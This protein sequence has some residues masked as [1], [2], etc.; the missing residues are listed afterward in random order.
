MQSGKVS[1]QS[2][3]AREPLDGKMTTSHVRGLFSGWKAVTVMGMK[4]SSS[5]DTGWLCAVGP[6]SR[7]IP[8]PQF[9]SNRARMNSI[10]MTGFLIF[11]LALEIDRLLRIKSGM[12]KRIRFVLGIH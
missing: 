2:V 5:T 6:L 3:P 11:I 1:E 9:I 7:P 4:E 10:S 8:P 12:G